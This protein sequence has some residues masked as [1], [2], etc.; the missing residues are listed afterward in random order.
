M[1]RHGADL[2]RA[3]QALADAP[4][5][6]RRQ[7][8]S[9]GIFGAPDG[10]AVV[11]GSPDTDF[12]WVVAYDG[13]PSAALVDCTAAVAGTHHAC[14]Q[15]ASPLND[16]RKCC[17]GSPAREARRRRQRRHGRAAPRRPPAEEPGWTNGRRP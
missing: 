1:F 17:R 8:I 13:D 3:R 15:A 9:A 11:R 7:V 6:A 16:M 4:T 10:D 14:A 12:M 5:S 2:L